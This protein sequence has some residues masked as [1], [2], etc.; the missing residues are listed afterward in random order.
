MR[1]H[2]AVDTGA[3]LSVSGAGWTAEGHTGS[4]QGQQRVAPKRDD[5]RLLSLGEDRRTRLRW[6]LPFTPL[7]NR[8]GIDP[9]LPAQR[10]ERSLRSLYC[11]SDGAR[12]RVTSVTN[13]SHKA[14]FHSFERTTPSNRGI[15]HLTA[16]V[17]DVNPRH[18]ELCSN[19]TSGTHKLTN[20]QGNVTF[21]TKLVT[22][23]TKL[24]SI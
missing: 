12:G 14:S 19:A 23:S 7:R 3:A 6:A 8:L 4:H 10:R 11:C 18:P 5:G 1:C 16:W 22:L 24:F 17:H 13:L 9:E 21:G 15:K 20:A 2:A